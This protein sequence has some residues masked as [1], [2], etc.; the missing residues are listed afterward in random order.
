MARSGVVALFRIDLRS[1]LRDRR[2]VIFSLV[3][4]LVVM[5]LFM[6]ASSTLEQKRQQRLLHET[7]TYAVTGDRP[8]LVQDTVARAIETA[9]T[10]ADG[11]GGAPA[12]TYVLVASDDPADD[13][14]AGR[15]DAYVELVTGE[16]ARAL[17]DADTRGTDTARTPDT[18]PALAVHYRS[19]DSTS[20]TAAGGL[21][22]ALE[23]EREELRENLMHSR[24]FPIPIDTV[25]VVTMVDLA[26]AE[27]IAGARIGGFLTTLLVFLMLVGGATVASDVIAGEKERGTLET[28][29]STAASRNEIVAAKLL[30]VLAVTITI[31]VLELASLL[32]YAS[33]HIVALPAGY[34]AL[35]TP[36]TIVL[37]FVLHVPVATFVSSVLLLVSGYSKSYKEAQLYFFPVILAIAALAIAPVLPGISLRSVVALVPVS[38][39]AVAAKQVLVGAYD[40]PM[41]IVAW[42]ATAGASVLLL[43]SAARRLSSEDLLGGGES[44]EI[45]GGPALFP[46]RVVRWFAM[47][48]V[49]IFVA[50]SYTSSLDIRWQVVVNLV[51]IFLGSSMLMLRIYRLDV[52]TALSLR[53]V[54]FASWLAVLVGAP[55]ALVVA[56]GV[57]RAANLVFP[58]PRQMIEEFGKALFPEGIPLW[59]MLLF[60]AVL[61][62]ICEEIAFRGLLLY[63]LRRRLRPVALCVTVG[64]VF[65]LFHFTLFRIASTAF[66]G[67]LLAAVTLLTGSIFPAML[68]HAINNGLGVIAAT[69]GVSDDGLPWWSALVALVPLAGS[70]WVLAR[71]RKSTTPQEA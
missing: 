2:T 70:F 59:Q 43:R 38:G 67:M 47:M 66:L 4:P 57:S 25:D 61:P 45:A 22:R 64:L 29:L 46:K 65:G 42:L 56:I 13:V 17:V 44:I 48:W 36:G 62:G 10:S 60:V 39:V 11:N 69:S 55:S 54:P 63:G 30:V 50:S 53:G 16:Q 23:S 18:A 24:G 49:A 20:R 40:W 28:L 71:S 9:R 58:V 19:D 1:L 33:L 15:L 32:A 6:F 7:F 27:Q 35:L 21:E 12:L 3:L 34:E 14:R 51:G 37:L 5:P 41:M 52:R 8:N 31:T 68:W 26:S